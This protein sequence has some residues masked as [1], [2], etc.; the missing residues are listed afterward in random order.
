MVLTTLSTTV[1]NGFTFDAGCIICLVFLP[2]IV[3]G[4]HFRMEIRGTEETSIGSER[5][6]WRGLSNGQAFGRKHVDFCEL[7]IRL[8]GTA[9]AL[10][11]NTSKVENHS[12]RKHREHDAVKPLGM[13]ISV[14]T[15]FRRA[16]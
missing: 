2:I 5:R 10:Q 13:P 8:V 14:P 9:L 11:E 15:K 6:G 12:V 4:D 1:S 3:R 16:S 7:H